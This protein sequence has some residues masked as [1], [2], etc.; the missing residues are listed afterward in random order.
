[1]KFLLKK[2][3]KKNRPVRAKLDLKQLQSA[4]PKS[5]STEKN[6][7]S[8]TRPRPLDKVRLYHLMQN[9]NLI[10]LNLHITSITY[11]AA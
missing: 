10:I 7:A 6:I 2:L 5:E 3:D 11:F 8:L 1:M 4:W 9:A